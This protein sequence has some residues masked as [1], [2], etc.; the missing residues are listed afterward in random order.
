MLTTTCRRIEERMI[1][2]RGRLGLEK[3]EERMLKC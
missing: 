1:E 2:C 3:K